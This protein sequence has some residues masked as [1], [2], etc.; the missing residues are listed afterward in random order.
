MLI[1]GPDGLVVFANT[2][3]MMS[4]FVRDQRDYPII[5]SKADLVADDDVLWL[6]FEYKPA[7]RRAHDFFPFDWKEEDHAD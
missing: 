2:F 4:G 7:I 6:G 3:D 1:T 5:I